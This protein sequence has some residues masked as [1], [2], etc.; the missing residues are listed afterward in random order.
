MGDDIF[1]YFT[2]PSNTNTTGGDDNS[3]TEGGSG[4]PP[5]GN[6]LQNLLTS[7]LGQN[8]E[9]NG[10]NTDDGGNTNRTPRM[11]VGSMVDG[12][13]RFQPMPGSMPTTAD[14]EN[15]ETNNNSNNNSEE[16]GAGLGGAGGRGNNIAR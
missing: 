6:F 3:T 12:N 5:L 2:P 8:V 14:N 7:M 13:V 4:N 10:I 9:L 16:A 11:F 1:Q 15:G